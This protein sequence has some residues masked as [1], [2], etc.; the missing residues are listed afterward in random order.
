MTDKIIQA[1]DYIENNRNSVNPRY[2]N[3]FHVMPPVG[4]INDPNG[5]NYA[6]GKYHLFFQHHPYSAEWGPM[7]WGHY[8]TEDFVVWKYRS[9][10]LAPDTDYDKDGCFSGSSYFDGDNF[11]I[12]YTAVSGDRQTQALAVSQDGIEFKK[13]GVVIDGDL[14]PEDNTET[15]FRDPKIFVRDGAYYCMVGATDKSGKGRILAYKSQNLTDWE[16]LGKVLQDDRTNVCECPDY[17][18]LDGK[19]VLIYSPQYVA[20][21]GIKYQNQHSNVYML[22]KLD[23]QTGAFEKTVEGELDSGF[24]FYAAQTLKTTDGRRVMIAWMS[25]WDR[26]PVTAPDGWTGAMTLPREL[27]VKDNRLYQSP[28]REIEKYRRVHYHEIKKKICGS[29]KL[30][31]FG[32]TQEI[33][34]TFAIGTAQRVGLKLFCGEKHETLIYYDAQKKCAVFDRSKMGREIGHG[35]NEADAYVR[36]GN[37][38]LKG[39]TLS[40]RLFLDVSSCEVFL[41]DGECVMTA[42]VYADKGDNGTYVFA[43]G[44]YSEIQRLDAYNLE[45]N[46]NFLEEIQ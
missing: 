39:G 26:T 30:P 38:T 23:L 28:V 21:D 32:A 11:S 5:F 46:K 37:V 15:D 1:N 16:Y 27:S 2:R 45:I 35:R 19:E 14:I 17:F 8:T 44:G 40:M 43:D 18:L 33:S 31:G 4:W 34:V 29:R 24:D 42:N 6:F 13:R 41:G 20:T 25:M 7:H 3:K 36:Y 10:A 12:L 9:V 22:G